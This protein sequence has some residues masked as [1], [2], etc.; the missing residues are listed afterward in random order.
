MTGNPR[1]L[2]SARVSKE[3]KA[4]IESEMKKLKLPNISAM[5]ETALDKYF[6]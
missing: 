2:V 6:A 4:K 5:I 1:V 3:V